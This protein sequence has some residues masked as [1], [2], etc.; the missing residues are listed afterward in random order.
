MLLR[1]WR[2]R[3]EHRARIVQESAAFAVVC[4]GC[5]TSV[6]LRLWPGVFFIYDLSPFNVSPMSCAH[7]HDAIAG[8]SGARLRD[9]VNR[10]NM[11]LGYVEARCA[12]CISPSNPRWR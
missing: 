7:V 6:G 9:P 11:P 8:R 4:V 5:L 12:D 10:R 1:F 2:R 3:S